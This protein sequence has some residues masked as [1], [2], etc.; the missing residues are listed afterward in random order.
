MAHQILQLN[1]FLLCYAASYSEG[2]LV[3][4]SCVL[5]S[6]KQLQRVYFL[7]T[8]NLCSVIKIFRLESA[9]VKQV[10][11]LQGCKKTH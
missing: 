5:Q 9:Y 2:T 8:S 4:C 1:A 3:Y 7:T 11:I 10:H 6:Q